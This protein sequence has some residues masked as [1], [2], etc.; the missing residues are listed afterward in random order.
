MIFAYYIFA[1]VLLFFSYRSFRGGID[2]YNFFKQELS[3]PLSSFTP[4]ATVIA[5]CKGI[6]D[7]L[8]E[9][10]SALLEQDHAEYE[11]IF[12]VD[13]KSDPAVNVIEKVSEKVFTSSRLCGKPLS[14]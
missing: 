14:K 6:D 4:F 7:G 12:V 2:Y 8:E 13:S 11:V 5:P 1:A 3:K 10:L 9:N